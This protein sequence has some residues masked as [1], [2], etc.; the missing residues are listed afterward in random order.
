MDYCHTCRRHLNGA[1]SCPGCGTIAEPSA[2]APPPALADTAQLP[3]VDGD[4]PPAGDVLGPRQPYE[5]DPYEADPYRSE[6]GG[7][8][9]RGS[10]RGSRQRAAVY[11]IGTV[12]VIGAATMFSLAALTGGSGGTVQPRSGV[13]DLPPAPGA[14]SGA[15]A[16]DDADLLPS[17]PTGSAGRSAS[18]SPSASGAPSPSATATTATAAPPPPPSPSSAPPK[19]VNPP[20]TPTHTPTHRPTH[21]PSPTAKPTSCVLIFC[22]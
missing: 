20:T 8:R 15:P 5:P 19:T 9:K 2:A 12:A 21:T 7:G 17:T 22:S 4:V 13:S 10:R 1:Y 3:V 6:P 11:G 16:S 14:S 18:A